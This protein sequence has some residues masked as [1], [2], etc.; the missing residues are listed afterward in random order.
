VLEP[1]D[2]LV[3]YTDGVTEARRERE[4]YGSARLRACVDAHRATVDAIVTEVLDDVLDYQQGTPRD[5]V[6]IVAVGVPRTSGPDA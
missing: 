5:D 1:G 6:A 3:L 4:L 2:T